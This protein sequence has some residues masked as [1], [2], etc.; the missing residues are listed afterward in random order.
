MYPLLVITSTLSRSGALDAYVNQIDGDTE[1]IVNALLAESFGAKHDT[2]SDC[3]LQLLEALLASRVTRTF[4]LKRV[5]TLLSFGDYSGHVDGVRI[6]LREWL[7][8]FVNNCVGRVHRLRRKSQDSLKVSK[9]RVKQPGHKDGSASSRNCLQK[10]CRALESAAELLV[11]VAGHCIEILDAGQYDFEA[12]SSVPARRLRGL[13]AVTDFIPFALSAVFHLQILWDTTSAEHGLLPSKLPLSLCATSERQQSVHAKTK[14]K[15]TPFDAYKCVSD[16]LRCWW[17]PAMLA[18]T[19][20]SFREV[21][22]VAGHMLPHS[23]AKQGELLYNLGAKLLDCTFHS[24]TAATEAKGTRSVCVDADQWVAF[25]AEASS[26]LELAARI[27]ECEPHVGRTPLTDNDCPLVDIWTRVLLW[28]VVACPKE[29]LCILYSMVVG[30]LSGRKEILW[31]LLASCRCVP[32]MQPNLVPWQCLKSDASGVALLLQMEKHVECGVPDD[33]DIQHADID[34]ALLSLFAHNTSQGVS[35][36]V[37]S[38]LQI[39]VADVTDLLLAKGLEWSR[40]AKSMRHPKAKIGNNIL[41]S[42]ASFRGSVWTSVCTRLLL[43]L[44]EGYREI[45]SCTASLTTLHEQMSSLFL[46]L[47][48]LCASLGSELKSGH[49]ASGWLDARSAYCAAFDAFIVGSIT[50]GKLETEF[51]ERLMFCMVPLFDDEHTRFVGLGVLQYLMS[52]PSSWESAMFGLAVLV[53]HLELQQEESGTTSLL[54]E[55]GRLPSSWPGPDTIRTQEDCIKIFCTYLNSAH[56]CYRETACRA[57]SRLLR[58]N[59]ILSEG[60]LLQIGSTIRTQWHLDHNQGILARMVDV[61]LA[62]LQNQCVV[63]LLDKGGYENNCGQ[64]TGIKCIAGDLMQTVGSLCEALQEPEKL[65]ELLNIADKAHVEGVPDHGKDTIVE[66]WASRA[67]SLCGILETLI[68]AQVAFLLAF[69]HPTEENSRVMSHLPKLDYLVEVLVILVGIVKSETLAKFMSRSTLASLVVLLTSHKIR[70]STAALSQILL[71]LRLDGEWK[72]ESPSSFDRGRQREMQ[73][74]LQ[75]CKT[76]LGILWMAPPLDCPFWSE[77]NMSSFSIALTYEGYL[78]E[79]A[80]SMLGKSQACKVTLPSYLLDCISRQVGG[81]SRGGKGRSQ[82]TPT[83][84]ATGIPGLHSPQ[85]DMSSPNS[86]R[87]RRR[88]TPKAWWDSAGG[89]SVTVDP[90]GSCHKRLS[91]LCLTRRKCLSGVCNGRRG[92]GRSWCCSYWRKNRTRSKRCSI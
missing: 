26:C 75:L 21:V 76:V 3:S 8:S 55:D 63:N 1:L 2:E 44:S 27:E 45:N 82:S 18:S 84:C 28:I 62:F 7:F 70:L 77:E 25:A 39:G 16:F 4:A 89:M 72:S 57:M 29:K 43:A 60:S 59:G 11:E 58:R 68:E 35:S 71:A 47:E 32:Q 54:A 5:L 31:C 13:H 24:G 53:P 74:S 40:S 88:R 30:T 19:L 12:F 6:K 81:S 37:E 90:Y 52:L 42:A 15:A 48:E 91:P 86:L 49:V 85:K 51:V 65:C 23:S 56:E 33:R 73:E 61:A 66:G 9:A 36:I 69:P 78:L 20:Q 67:T 34:A 92:K 14:R 87:K 22:D 17:P 79:F 46:I 50:G 41:C 38:I 80:R 83:R 64:L 10:S